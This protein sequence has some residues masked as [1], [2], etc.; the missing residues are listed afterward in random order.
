MIIKMFLKTIFC[1]PEI[2]D[3]KTS[4]LRLILKI[5]SCDLYSND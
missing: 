3:I 2:T 4:Y 1:E 5:K